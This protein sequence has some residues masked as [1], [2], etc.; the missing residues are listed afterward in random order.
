MDV[1]GCQLQACTSVQRNV[2]GWFDITQ[3]GHCQRERFPV[4]I[5]QH[6][7]AHYYGFP[8]FSVKG[9]SSPG[10]CAS[11]TPCR[12]VTLNSALEQDCYHAMFLAQS[13]HLVLIIST[14]TWKAAKW[15]LH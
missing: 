4:Y 15:M 9:R 12:M 6:E 7:H 11:A 13:L 2:I 8:E 10:M 1:R 5:L 3:S 14:D